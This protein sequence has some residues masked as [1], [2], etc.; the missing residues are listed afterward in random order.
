MTLQRCFMTLQRCFMAQTHNI[1]KAHTPGAYTCTDGHPRTHA[2]TDTHAHTR[3]LTMYI[4]KRIHQVHTLVHVHIHVHTHKID[5][6]AHTRPSTVHIHKHTH[7]CTYT[8][9]RQCTDT[10]HTSSTYT[11]TFIHP[12]T[13]THTQID[14]DA[15]I[16]L[17]TTPHRTATHHTAPHCTATHHTTSSSPTRPLLLTKPYDYH[18]LYHAHFIHLD[19]RRLVYDETFALAPRS[20][21]QLP[22]SPGITTLSHTCGRNDQM[23]NPQDRQAQSRDDAPSGKIRGAKASNRDAPCRD[24]AARLGR[25]LTFFG[26]PLE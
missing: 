14:A 13:H 9:R 4:H 3:T 5:T 16:H 1:H 22:M 19:T 7:R 26:P 2:Q 15:R 21:P 10:E 18:S 8:Y 23:P 12:R 17:H 24:D 6:H 25:S 20:P 11:C